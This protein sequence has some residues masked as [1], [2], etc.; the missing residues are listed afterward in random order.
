MALQYR[1]KGIFMNSHAQPLYKGIEAPDRYTHHH[2]DRSITGDIKALATDNWHGPFYIVK[3]Y[4]VI[5]TL[6]WLVVDV[7][8]WFYPLAVIMIG[9]HQRG[10]STILHDSAHGVLTKNRLLNFLLGTWPTAWPIFQRHFAYKESHVHSHHP[11]LGRVDADPDLEFFIK[12]GVFTPRTDRSFI[13]KIIV[14]PLLGSK[15]YA[16]FRYLVRNRYQVIVASVSGKESAT[17]VQRG[18]GWRCEFDRWG[19]YAFWASIAAAGLVSGYFLEF[20]LLWVVPYVT[21]F[22]IIGWF[23]EMS[24]HCSSIDNQHVNLHM[25]R[26]RQ[27]RNI[28]KW[29]TGINNDNYHLDHHLDPTTPFWRLPEAHAI[30]MRDLEYAAHCSETGG[31]FQSGPNGEPSILMLIRDQN[32][33]RFIESALLPA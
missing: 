5:A 27:S 2:F 8:W 14:L 25:A 20:L 15:T 24:E 9:A 13:W 21:S 23:I 30:R 16:Y 6:V 7:S 4:A 18:E 28:E 11:F 32:R 33:K 3:D 31:I 12:E 22:H 17:R 1:A 26:N 29:L 19:F 10:I